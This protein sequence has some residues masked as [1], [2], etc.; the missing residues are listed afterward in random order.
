MF[1]HSHKEE[2]F[3]Q[4]VKDGCQSY[5]PVVVHIGFVD[6]VNNARLEADR[7]GSTGDIHNYW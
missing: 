4:L 2:G 7:N 3:E 6:R 1:G 5:P